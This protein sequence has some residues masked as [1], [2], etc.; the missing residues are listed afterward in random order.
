MKDSDSGDEVNFEPIIPDDDTLDLI[1]IENL[2]GNRPDRIILYFDDRD[3]PY[4][5][6][7]QSSLNEAEE[8]FII[9]T[10][11]YIDE[12]S[13][14]NKDEYCEIIYA[15]LGNFPLG[16]NLSVINFQIISLDEALD[17]AKAIGS[18]G[19]LIKE[20]QTKKEYYMYIK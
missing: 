16:L 9:A 19:L 13:T 2:I 20:P 4:I 10:G 14:T 5:F 17:F 7:R 1:S 12:S 15:Q 18:N 6:D 8:R 3:S 11:V